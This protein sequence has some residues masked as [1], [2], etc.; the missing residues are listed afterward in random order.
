MTCVSGVEC[1]LTWD[2]QG[3]GASCASIVATVTN[4]ADG[5]TVDGSALDN[6]GSH[7]IVVPGSAEVSTY[8]I[9]LACSDGTC[10]SD[11]ATF[12]VSYTF[13]PPSRRRFRR[14]RQAVVSADGH[15]VRRAHAEA[16]AFPDPRP[17][18]SPTPEPS[19]EPT[20]APTPEPTAAP[21]GCFLSVVSIGSSMTC[22]SGVE[23]TLT[24]DYQGD[25]ASCASIVATVTNTADGSTVDGSAL[26]N[27]GSHTIVVPGSAEV[28]T[29]DITLACSDG[30]CASDSATFDVSYTFPPS[31]EPTTVSPTTSVPSRAPTA[32]PSV[33]PASAPTPSP[34]WAPTGCSVG[35]VDVGTLFT[36]VAG[37]EC[38]LSWEYRGDAAACEDVTVTVATSDGAVV[39]SN[40]IANDESHSV[41]V[42]AD[43]EV[44]SYTLT[45]A[46][47]D[48]TCASDSCVVD[49][50]YTPHPTAAPT[51]ATPPAEFR[52]NDDRDAHDLDAD[53]DADDVLPSAAPTAATV[54][55]D[56]IWTAA[57]GNGTNLTVI[58]ASDSAC[59]A[60]QT[61]D[62]E[63]IAEAYVAAVVGVS[64]DAVSNLTCDSERVNASAAAARRLSRPAPHAAAVLD[65]ETLVGST[66]CD[67]GTVV[68]KTIAPSNAPTTAAPSTAP[69]GAPTA[70]P[71]ARRRR[72]PSTL[73]P[74]T[75]TAA[76]TS[77]SDWDVC[78]GG[79]FQISVETADVVEDTLGD[80]GVLRYS[81]V[82]YHEGRG[83]DLVVSG[84]LTVAHVEY[85]GKSGSFGQI[86]VA[87]NTTA[88]LKFSLVD[89]E[90]DARSSST[91]VARR[92]AR[93]STTF[94][95]LR[96]G[97]LCDNPTDANNLGA[98][99]CGDCDQ[100]A[101]SGLDAYFPVDQSARHHVR[102]QVPRSSFDVYL[103]APCETCWADRG[104]NFVFGGESNL[105][106]WP[107]RA[108]T[109]S[110]A[111]VAPGAPSP[112][113]TTS[114]PSSP[115]TSSTPSNAPTI[116]MLP[117]EAPV[118]VTLNDNTSAVTWVDSGYGGEPS[119]FMLYDMETNSTNV[120]TA[121]LYTYDARRRLATRLEQ[122][123]NATE[124]Q[125][126]RVKEELL[127]RYGRREPRAHQFT[128]GA[129]LPCWVRVNIAIVAVNAAGSSEP[130]VP[131]SKMLSRCFREPSSA[132][133]FLPSPLPSS[134]S[135]SASP[136]PTSVSPTATGAPTSAS[137]TATGAPTSRAV[138][139]ADDG[140]MELWDAQKHVVEAV[141]NKT[142]DFDDCVL[143]FDK[144]TDGD[145]DA[146]LSVDADYGCAAY[147]SVGCDWAGAPDR[148]LDDGVTA[149]V[150]RDGSQINIHGLAG[151]MPNISQD[152]G[153][154]DIHLH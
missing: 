16:Y 38:A 95:A 152:G 77:C 51:T 112:S 148:D 91:N 10:A 143:D 53:R 109:F 107:S 9:T 42:S 43:A 111:P 34:S 72:A 58:N 80:G 7:T 118:N 22:V 103:A 74:S 75:E 68:T 46:C 89:S 20:P 123:A 141:P 87:D 2:Y 96:P 146:V 37:V 121:A 113:P 69:T 78:N 1:T 48:G 40:T 137:P 104:R 52:A 99:A 50:S 45:L 6:D 114:A 32:S 26:D 136:A 28:S 19:P 18:P 117:P 15:S 14:R 85:M 81:P 36:C 30:T 71:T 122:L 100:C 94:A 54:E 101:S 5:S 11:S 98:V 135:P 35:I 12:D 125:L 133:T 76:P 83:V 47:A 102:L 115:P 139:P 67:V 153:A 144:M 56:V 59:S 140:G 105:C 61:A 132:P 149:V 92:R 134:A 151:R 73:A 110:P 108:P 23:C 4:T 55:I 49:V 17:T 130:S 31:P 39:A 131:D 57:A 62:G 3:D 60:V 86:N 84:S 93:S 138:P 64:V 154:I 79:A 21:T 65:N 41:V 127:A 147:A 25:G 129:R 150:L 88:A 13:P 126:A 106:A 119:S 145:G 97:F 90:T 63:V 124:E 128:L 66:V 70:P 29:Y 33:E 120:T 8:D 142:I 27:D 116:P 82:G 44:N 24:W